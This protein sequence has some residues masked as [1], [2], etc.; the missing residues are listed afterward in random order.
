MPLEEGVL[1]WMQF[2][3]EVER[4]LGRETVSVWDA[5]RIRSVRNQQLRALLTRIID[6][7]GKASQEAQGLSQP[8]TSV[9]RLESC[10]DQILYLW[11]EE[12]AV[13]GLLKIG[14]KNLFIRTDIGT[15]KEIRP[16]CVLDFF[17]APSRQR[18]GLGKALFEHM[19]EAQQVQAHRLAYD[20]PSPKLLGF[21]A[22]HYGLK[23]YTPQANNFVVFK[24]YFVE[25]SPKTKADQPLVS[26]STRP[27]GR[28]AER[29][30]SFELNEEE[31]YASS[32]ATSSGKNVD[33]L[34]ASPPI[35]SSS[36]SSVSAGQ[37]SST[38]IG[39]KE[40]SSFSGVP[41][42]RLNGAA[43]YQKFT[44]S[45]APSAGS[46]SLPTGGEATTPTPTT[47]AFQQEAAKVAALYH[48]K[49]SRPGGQGSYSA[50]I[51]QAMRGQVNRR[52]G[53]GQRSS[54]LNPLSNPTS[55]SA[56]VPQRGVH[57]LSRPRPSDYEPV[58]SSSTASATSA[59]SSV[60]AP[61]VRPLNYAVPPRR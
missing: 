42:S 40:N 55:M 7:M 36:S 18:Q 59:S 30:D 46:V 16:L 9:S 2:E 23:S 1:A 52:G 48:E 24:K 4:V 13:L 60:S 57:P 35:S 12:G 33:I 50:G 21:L 31:E 17:V 47:A 51:E 61:I 49:G 29:E 41:S 22:K 53:A 5:S 28:F 11:Q 15:Y 58:L 32:S 10:P 45:G 54:P 44:S 34:P 38:Q 8:I 26:V 19:M 6:A 3:G 20:R 25:G 43:A 39:G 27:I 37:G 56:G 14:Y